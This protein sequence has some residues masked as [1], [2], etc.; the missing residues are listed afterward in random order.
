MAALITA[1]HQSIKTL[2]L[3]LVQLYDALFF[4][5]QQS[6]SKGFSLLVLRLACELFEPTHRY[7]I[8]VL[9]AVPCNHLGCHQNI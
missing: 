9:I 7:K 2:T 8:C 5:P 4:S 3:V 1:Y 6:I